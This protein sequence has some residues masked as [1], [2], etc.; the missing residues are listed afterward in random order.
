MFLRG[1]F[2][3][4]YIIELQNIPSIHTY[5]LHVTLIVQQFLPHNV[6]I[7][8]VIFC[9]VFGQMCTCEL[10]ALNCRCVMVLYVN[11]T[12]YIMWD[13]LGIYIFHVTHTHI[14]IHPQ[15]MVINGK[16]NGLIEGNYTEWP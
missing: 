3:P 4:L 11:S 2:R 5:I 6:Y 7:H 9:I 13:I 1:K 14:H 16:K 8:T 10:R 15:V 12:I